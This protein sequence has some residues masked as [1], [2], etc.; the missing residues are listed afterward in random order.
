MVENLPNWPNEGAR[1]IM[2]VNQVAIIVTLKV[3][4]H[5]K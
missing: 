4:A 5:K 1:A 3:C 2:Q